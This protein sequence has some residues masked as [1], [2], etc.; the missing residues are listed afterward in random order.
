MVA[1]K[2][3]RE[4]ERLEALAA[5]NILDTAAERSF[6]D[7]VNLAS[8]ICEAPIGLISLVDDDRQWFKARH[9]EMPQETD[10]TKSVCAHAILSPEPLVIEDT[11]LDERTRDNPLNDDPD[12]HMR[13][14]AGVPLIDAP[15]LPLG[16]LCVLD[17]KPRRLTEFQ[18]NALSVLS[19]Q[20]VKEIRLRRA[21]SDAQELSREL[22]GKSRRLEVALEEQ[23]TLKA[24]IDHRVKN[25]L[26]I[27][28]SLIAMQ[29]A[30][31]ESADVKAALDQAV[32]RVRA[33][34]SIHAELNGSGG[35]G[36]VLLPVY[37]ERLLE[38]LRASAPEQVDLGLSAD[39][40]ISVSAM[41]ATSLA[42]I[43]N[44]FVTNSLKYAFPDHRPG[45]V[46]LRLSNT[47]G[48]VQL[49]LRDDGIGSDGPLKGQGLGMKIMTT[50][51]QQLGAKV[52]F[53]S[54]GGGTALKLEFD[55]PPSVAD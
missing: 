48:T 43:T 47:C 55:H 24:E 37:L 44:E 27:V 18:M 15:G 11:T 38:Q 9:G 29:A 45:R 10:L 3:P 30:R 28:A 41:Q 4:Q 25:S 22:E 36:Q 32:S 14:Y 46:E 8:E 35:D 16:T 17:S 33:I 12:V 40:E 21:L 20:V 1:P 34:S 49:E 5:L 26:Q 42:I 54:P 39:S 51:A 7:L 50:V 6:D 19:R 52:S 2:H 23:R 13:F 31:S 53:H